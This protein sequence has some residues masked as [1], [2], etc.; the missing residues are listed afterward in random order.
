MKTGLVQNAWKVWEMRPLS[1]RYGSGL[2]KIRS[3]NRRSFP[4]SWTYRPN[5][6]VPHEGWSKHKST[7]PLKGTLLTPALK[8]IRQTRAKRLF[9]RHTKNKHKI[10]LFRDEKIFTIEEQYNNQ[11]NMIYAQKDLEVHSEGAWRH[12][13]SNIMFSG[14]CP[15]RGWHL[16]IFWR[17]L[18]KTHA[19]VYQED[20]Q[21]GDVKLLNMTVFNDQIWVFQQNWA[22][23]HKGKMTQEW[24]QG[25]FRPLSAPGIG[26]QGV[27]T[28]TPW[29]TNC[30]L[31]WRTWLAESIT[32]TW[33]ALR[34]PP[35]NG[36]CN[37][38]RVAGA[39]QGL[40]RVESGHFEWHYY[41][42]TYSLHGAESFLRS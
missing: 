31:F 41:L 30:G 29:T 40:H 39:S 6:V 38:S 7:P 13:P 1:K 36:A 3:G 8:E 24:L 42:L 27:Q 10:I 20:V 22:P 35:G 26:P 14:G 4:E 37:N 16:F 25:M 28:S 34:Q 17:K 23:A 19:W 18:W 9:Q 21:Q 33:T 15:I 2:T 5:Q 11:Y 32:T 12:R